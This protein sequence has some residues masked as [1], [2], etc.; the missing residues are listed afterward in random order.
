MCKKDMDGLEIQRKY[1]LLP[2]HDGK[3]NLFPVAWD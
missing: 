1:A 2:G 3:A